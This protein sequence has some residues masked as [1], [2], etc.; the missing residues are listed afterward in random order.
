M[1]PYD[2]DHVGR[3]PSCHC[4]LS[5]SDDFREQAKRWRRFAVECAEQ[6]SKTYWLR[7]ADHWDKLAQNV[8]KNAAE[9]ADQT[10]SNSK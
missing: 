5:D 3:A 1:P 4:G 2:C 6:E 10:L 7:L 8:D 9:P